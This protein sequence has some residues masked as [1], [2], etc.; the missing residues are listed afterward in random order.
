MTQLVAESILV[1]AFLG[2]TSSLMV[3]ALWAYRSLRTV[4]RYRRVRRFLSPRGSL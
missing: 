3:L 1:V 4:V 2:I